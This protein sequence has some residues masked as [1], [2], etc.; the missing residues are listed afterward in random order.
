MEM[1]S[2][3]F[4]VGFGGMPVAMDQDSAASRT[5]VMVTLAIRSSSSIRWDYLVQLAADADPLL[6]TSACRC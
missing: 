1:A 5:S 3:S 2:L 4:S 6:P